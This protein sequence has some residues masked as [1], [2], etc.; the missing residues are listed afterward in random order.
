MKTFPGGFVGGW[1][2]NEFLMKTPSPKFG[3][4][5]QR[6]TSDLESVNKCPYRRHRCK[7]LQKC[8]KQQLLGHIRQVDKSLTTRSDKRKKRNVRIRISMNIKEKSIKHL[9]ML[10]LNVLN[11]DDNKDDSPTIAIIIPP[12]FVAVTG[13][14]SNKRETEM[15]AILLVTLA[16]A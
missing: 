16:T 1:L 11:N 15:T 8:V 2:E 13:F 4:E 12:R 5:S 10:M 7:L 6:G 14:L 3:L 9:P